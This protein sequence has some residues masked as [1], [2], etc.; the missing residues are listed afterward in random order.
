MQVY[1]KTGYSGVKPATVK[2]FPAG[3]KIVAGRLTRTRPMPGPDYVPRDHLGVRQ[4]QWGR[5]DHIPTQRGR[6][7]CAPG[8]WLV[9]SVEFPQ[10]WDGVNLDSPDHKSHMAY[11][12]T[13]AAR[14]R[15]RSLARDLPADLY[16]VPAGGHPDGWRLSQRQLRLQR[17]ERRLQRS[18][19]LGGTAGTPRRSR[20][21]PPAARTCLETVRWT[22]SATA[23]SS[24][25]ARTDAARG[26]RSARLRARRPHAM[27][28]VR[29]APS[30]MAG[31]RDGVATNTGHA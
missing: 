29:T 3:L 27:T 10:C 18:R 6:R 28:G 13:V 9:M 12:S 24:A 25:S 8:T 7:C 22:C 21:G 15:T 5:F 16:T 4:R 17:F 20:R 2:P 11:P 1:Y 31:V 23:S 30:M 14:R 26:G 19:R